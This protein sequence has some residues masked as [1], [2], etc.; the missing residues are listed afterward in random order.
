MTAPDEP[1]L[2]VVVVL[3]GPE[4]AVM[5]VVVGVETGLFE[6]PVAILSKRKSQRCHHV[7]FSRRPQVS[8][9]REH[10]KIPTQHGL[11]VRQRTLF[12]LSART[13]I[14]VKDTSYSKTVTGTPYLDLVEYL[15]VHYGA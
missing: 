2:L 6:T 9:C 10:T 15:R 8:T 14:V 1:A 4:E 7:M 11:V 12:I 3:L 5:E 13:Q